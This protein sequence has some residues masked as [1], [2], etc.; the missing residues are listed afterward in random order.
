MAATANMTLAVEKSTDVEHA[1]EQEEEQVSDCSCRS[2]WRNWL[3]LGAYI[4]NLVITYISLTGVF[5]KTNTELSSKYQTL[6]TPAGWAFSIWGPIFI[7]EAVFVVTQL[8]PRFRKSEVVHKM[9]PWWWALCFFQC[10]WTFSFA[11]D[12]V[13]LALIFM[14]SILASLL[15]ISW[16]TDGLAMSYAEYFLLRAPLSLQLGWIVCA[17]AVNI[18]VQADALKASQSVLLAFAVFTYA[19]VM[20]ISTAFTWAL[21]SPDAIVSLV[22]A[23]AFAGIYSKLGD[24]EELNDPTRFNPSTWDTV[25]LDGLR[26][27]ALLVSLATLVN[28]VAAVVLRV[29]RAHKRQRSLSEE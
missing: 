5:G 7:W 6:V 12:Q 10:C 29:V 8:F 16:S 14:I 2:M 28:A 18:N 19:A 22:A 11:Q 20:S 25:I 1:E 4:V 24:P 13:T 17:S 27:A 3:N 9:S 21:H 15:G 26:T 23:W